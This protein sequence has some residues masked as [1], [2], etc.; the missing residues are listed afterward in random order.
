MFVHEDIGKYVSL[1][2]DN[3]RSFSMVLA[4]SSLARNLGECTTFHSAPSLYF[5]F[6]F[7][8]LKWKLARAHFFH[9]LG[10]N[11]STVA[12]R[13]ETTVAEHSPTSCV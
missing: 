3:L 1:L 11:Q 10:Q 6:L 8:C 12:Q 9:F 7:V 4:S 5:C 13:A 2:T